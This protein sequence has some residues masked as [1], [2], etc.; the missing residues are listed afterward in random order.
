MTRWTLASRVL[1]FMGAATAHGA[2]HAQPSDSAND[3]ELCLLAF[4]QAQALRVDGQLIAAR[5]QLVI[6]AQPRC[7]TAV[8]AKCTEWLGEL[9][10]EGADGDHHPE[11][12]AR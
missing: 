12:T 10:A 5:A 4:D 2:A 11:S 1:A 3:E 9:D 7:M 6:C 8:Q